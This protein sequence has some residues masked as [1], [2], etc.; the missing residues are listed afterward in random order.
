MAEGNKFHVHTS[1]PKAVARN[2]GAKYRA[3][4]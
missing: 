1:E 4:E 2:R 3:E